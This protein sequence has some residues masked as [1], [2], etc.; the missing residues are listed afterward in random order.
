MVGIGGAQFRD[1]HLRDTVALIERLPLDA[2]DLVYLSPFVS[3]GST[4]YDMDMQAA[5]IAPLDGE[6][7]CFE[8]QRCKLAL[9]AVAKRTGLRVSHYDLRE[10][11]Y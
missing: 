1:A 8:E 10:F 6:A 4:R 9:Q 11:V 7:M 3:D 5:A 2:G